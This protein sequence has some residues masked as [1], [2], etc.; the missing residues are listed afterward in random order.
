VCTILNGLEYTP[1]SVLQ[2]HPPRNTSINC[3]QWIIA[4][5]P[6]VWSIRPYQEAAIF[7]VGIVVWIERS[8]ESVHTQKCTCMTWAHNN[9]S[10]M[11]LSYNIPLNT[12]PPS[13]FYNCMFCL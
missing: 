12:V 9:L 8:Q 5:C 10:W 6:R 7:I 13:N 11:P 3:Q 1:K 2:D 4:Y